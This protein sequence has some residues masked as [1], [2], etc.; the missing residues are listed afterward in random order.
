MFI[1]KTY[2]HLQLQQ[3]DHVFTFLLHRKDINKQTLFRRLITAKLFCIYTQWNRI[4]WFWCLKN[5]SKATMIH[6]N[7]DKKYANCLES[8]FF[9]TFPSYRWRG[10]ASIIQKKL[11]EST[12]SNTIISVTK[13]SNTPMQKILQKCGFIYTNISYFN[14]FLQEQVR[15]YVYTNK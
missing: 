12:L 7:S 14:Q 1:C 8:W 5:P 4:L 10:I 3:L 2:K 11:I 6:L 15:I 9:Y 13:V